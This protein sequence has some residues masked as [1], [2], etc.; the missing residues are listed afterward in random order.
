MSVDDER[1]VKAFIQT[2][3]SGVRLD[4]AQKLSLQ[5]ILA[6]ELRRGQK[7]R[8]ENLADKL[9]GFWETTY[10]ISLAP[11]VAA[12]VVVAAVFCGSLLFPVFVRP[13]PG[14]APRYFTRQ[15]SVG[16]DGAAQI[17]YIPVD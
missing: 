1:K 14:A 8:P 15:V 13:E 6:A 9:R 10:E 16:A 7:T 11:A 4:E 3:L 12:V 2:G 17:T 5:T